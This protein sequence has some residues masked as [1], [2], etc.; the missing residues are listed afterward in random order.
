MLAFSFWLLVR[1]PEQSVKP[2]HRRGK[3]IEEAWVRSGGTTRRASR[4]EIGAL[5][6]HSATPRW[7][8][9]RASDLITIEDV[10]RLLDLRTIAKLLQRPLPEDPDSLALWLQE[11]GITV[12][13]GRSH[14]ITNFGAI[15]A[16]SKLDD[17]PG[18]A[19][20]RVR[21]IRYRGTNKVDTIDELH[22]WLNRRTRGKSLS[23]RT[24]VH[25]LQRHPLLPPRITHAWTTR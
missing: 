10:A 25:L 18:L 12:P 22:K 15:A 4:Q 23:W 19:R 24:Y 6:L 2:V 13:D 17:F 11:E 9:L 7:E 1:I 8:D 21:V 20:K 14:Y 5:M 16:A 3:S